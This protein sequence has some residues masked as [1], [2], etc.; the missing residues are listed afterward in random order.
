MIQENEPVHEERPART[1]FSTIGTLR[2]LR[3]KPGLARDVLIAYRSGAHAK[4]LVTF[5]WEDHWATPLV[6][7]RTL[8]GLPTVPSVRHAA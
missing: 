8:L 3:E 4:K 6:E 2:G 1:G 5:P 7:V